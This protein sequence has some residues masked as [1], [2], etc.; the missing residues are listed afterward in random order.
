MVNINGILRNR[1]NIVNGVP[2]GSVLGPIFLILDV[3]SI[4]I[5]PAPKV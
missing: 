5:T 2:H 3:N 4:F 1:K